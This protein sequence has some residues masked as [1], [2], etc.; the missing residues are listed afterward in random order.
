[1]KKK[2][3]FPEY[4]E[5]LQFHLRKR[6]GDIVEELYDSVIEDAATE[7]KR[8]IFAHEHLG[9]F[10]LSKDRFDDAA[11]LLRKSPSSC[12]ERK[13]LLAE[14]VMKHG[15]HSWDDLMECLQLGNCDVINLILNKLETIKRESDVNATLLSQH[16]PWVMIFIPPPATT[17]H[18]L[19]FSTYLR[20]I[21]FFQFSLKI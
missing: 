1:M 16:F 9:K 4:L 20:W 11:A 13:Y 15:K 21:I 3:P 14:S 8:K 10:Y 18:S 12:N 19:L 17:K 7:E 2:S 5:W 6:G